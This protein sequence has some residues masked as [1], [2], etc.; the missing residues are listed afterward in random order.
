MVLWAAASLIGGAILTPWIYSAGKSLAEYTSTHEVIGILEDLGGS[1]G[2][3]EIGRYFSRAW[4]FSALVGIPFLV[5]RVRNIGRNNNAGKIMD[6][7]KLGMK[8]DIL[9]LVSGF[10]I[11]GGILWAIGMI[12][13]EA[14]AFV[15]RPD[16]KT[17]KL[18]EK[19]VVP[20]IGAS[21]LEEWLFRGLVLGLWMRTSG[22]LKAT[23]YSSLLFAFLHFLRPPGGVDD[24][25]SVFAGFELVGKILLQFTE[26]RFFVT[27]FLTLTLIGV[28]LCWV[29]LR[30]RSLWLA[31]GLH[32][33]LVFA[34]LA[35]KLFH[36][37]AASPLHPWGVGNTLKSGIFPILALL[38]IAVVCHYV[39]RQL[40][41]ECRK[42]KAED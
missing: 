15:P 23:I 3:A 20:A 22:A 11:A 8:Q 31:I 25:R 34:Y 13:T 38:V 9:H 42:E 36:K 4:M 14:G 40:M 41:C 2:R 32:A 5:R 12:L 19:C 7:D 18:F 10:I 21:L 33:G 17:S 29:T 1:C 24:P 27:D 6:F 35:F 39:M 26:P 30:T 37:S 16:P 28:L